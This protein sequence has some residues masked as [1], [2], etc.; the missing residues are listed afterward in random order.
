[1]N[2]I[3]APEMSFAH[4]NLPALIGEIIDLL[5]RNAA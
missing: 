4:P 3:P 2:N 1:M 5:Q